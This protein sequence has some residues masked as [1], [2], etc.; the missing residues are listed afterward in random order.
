MQG[1]YQDSH[2]SVPTRNNLCVYVPSST[3]APELEKLWPPRTLKDT[4]FQHGV[5]VLAFHDVL[6]AHPIQ[7]VVSHLYAATSTAILL[8]APHSTHSAPL[9]T[10]DC[11]PLLSVS[12]ETPCLDFPPCSAILILHSL[13]LLCSPLTTREPQGSELALPS[14]RFP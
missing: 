1:D 7:H 13:P 10:G 3:W 9:Q 12:M 11:L 4:L 6:H 8:S 2:L 5:S 14:L